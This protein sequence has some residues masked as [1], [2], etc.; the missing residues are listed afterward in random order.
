MA[1]IVRRLRRIRY[2]RNRLPFDN[3]VFRD[4][5]NPLESLSREEIRDRY[6]F[7]P[8]SV[9]YLCQLVNL[10]RDTK[11]S[12]PLPPLLT[13]LVALHFFA[14]GTH[15]IVTATLHGISRS[16]VCRAVKQFTDALCEL[17]NQFVN[18]PVGDALTTVQRAFYNIAGTVCFSI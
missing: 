13:T 8:E 11:R 12:S 16:S 5:A 1:D 10:E 6:R 2:I 7:Y 18:M 14:T 4:R 3:R 9:I 17:I 15:H